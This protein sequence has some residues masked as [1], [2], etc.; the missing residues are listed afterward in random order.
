[1]WTFNKKT[2]EKGSLHLDGG[3]QVYDPQVPIWR[4]ELGHA[5]D[6]REKHSSRIEWR[7]AWKGEIKQ[8]FHE[9]S[10]Y[11]KTSAVEGW[12][13]YARLVF[14]Q[15]QIA[16]AMFPKCWKYWENQGFV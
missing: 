4:H 8:T 10:D 7:D 14:A 16:K 12:A 15:P 6:G 9:L 3:D 2:N 11:A 5:L 1:M 13:E